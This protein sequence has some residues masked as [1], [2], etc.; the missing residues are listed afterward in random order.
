[1]C[2]YTH[3][4]THWHSLPYIFCMC[5]GNCGFYNLQ[6]NFQISPVLFY[7]HSSQET[8]MP[9][10][11]LHLQSNLVLVSLDPL[12]VTMLPNARASVL[13]RAHISM[14]SILHLKSDMQNTL[15]LNSLDLPRVTMFLITRMMLGLGWGKTTAALSCRLSVLL[16]VV[17][18]SLHSH[19]GCSSLSTF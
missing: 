15:V 19:L 14:L 13:K 11:N 9:P 8:S 16:Y 18:K 10:Q 6:V 4:H 3:T 1:M 17:K 12:R 7:Q 2:I 5:Y